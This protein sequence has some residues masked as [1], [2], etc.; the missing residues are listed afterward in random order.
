MNKKTLLSLKAILLGTSILLTGCSNKNKNTGLYYIKSDEGNIE[1]D[2]RITYE[3][4]KDY[5]FITLYN[6]DTEETEN[7]IVAKKIDNRSEES[8]YKYYD[9]LTGKVIFKEPTEEIIE[10]T[11]EIMEVSNIYKVYEVSMDYYLTKEDLIRKSYSQ[12]NV[13]TIIENLKN[14]YQELNSGKTLKLK[15]NNL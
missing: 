8:E 13:K 1:I 12:A 14:D 9:V 2:G 15:R 6:Y 4:M 11:E 3:K 7:Y 5:K 10:P